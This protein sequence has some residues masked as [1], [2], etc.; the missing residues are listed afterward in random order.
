MLQ[1]GE[2][3]GFHFVERITIVNESIDQINIPWNFFYLFRKGKRVKLNVNG[4][5]HQW[6]PLKIKHQSNC[7]V[8]FVENKNDCL[9]KVKRVVKRLLN[10]VKGRMITTEQVDNLYRDKVVR[11]DRVDELVENEFS[12]IK[13]YLS[14]LIVLD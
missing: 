13:M 9:R 7:D 1:E 8:S 14:Y 5:H 11:L 10:G 3:H 12:S 2:K 4:L 6:L